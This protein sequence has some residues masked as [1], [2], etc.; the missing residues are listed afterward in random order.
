MF[1]RLYP[2]YFRRDFVLLVDDVKKTRELWLVPAAGEGVQE[3]K[4][5]DN[6]AERRPIR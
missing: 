5:L 2:I 6:A 4:E 1:K 3:G